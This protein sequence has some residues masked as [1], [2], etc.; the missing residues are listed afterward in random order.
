M[1]ADE[2]PLA[3]RYAASLG[4]RLY[5]IGIGVRYRFG[6]EEISLVE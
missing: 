5:A 1:T 2:P 6:N 4:V 3:A